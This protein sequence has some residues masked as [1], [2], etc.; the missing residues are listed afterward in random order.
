M[1]QP[2]IGELHKGLLGHVVNITA[3]VATAIGVA[4]TLGF[5][6]IQIA[7]GLERVLGITATVG[8]QL[9]IIAV[10]FVLYMA[11]STS[12]VERGIKWLSSANLVLAGLLMLTI[13]LGL[14]LY[15]LWR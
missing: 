15:G 11:S 2:V 4:T 9:A 6:T 8:V 3:V 1:L 10:A 7:A 14:L 13:L 5:G 12:G